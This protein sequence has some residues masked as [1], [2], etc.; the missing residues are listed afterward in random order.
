M[1]TSTNP[2]SDL[3]SSLFGAHMKLKKKIKD[4]CEG[5]SSLN[6]AHVLHVKNGNS[7]AKGLL[8]AAIERESE[9]VEQVS[10]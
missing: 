6:C 9:R 2:I 4:R 7:I 8:F 10:H 5:K 3:S 1:A